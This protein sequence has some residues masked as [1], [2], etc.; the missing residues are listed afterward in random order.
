[1]DF[2]PEARFMNKNWKRVEKNEAASNDVAYQA[3]E[4]S[5]NSR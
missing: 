2:K 3:S 5:S 1:L 4:L